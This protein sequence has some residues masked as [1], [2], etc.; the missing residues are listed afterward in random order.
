MPIH[1]I[2][3]LG[4]LEASFK[5]KALQALKTIHIQ[6][7]L[8]LTL[9]QYINIETDVYTIFP[10]PKSCHEDHE[11]WAWTIIFNMKKWIYT[12]NMC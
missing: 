3:D 12:N 1:F 10:L 8:C 6:V 4:L 9:L 7:K 2:E 5:V 11:V